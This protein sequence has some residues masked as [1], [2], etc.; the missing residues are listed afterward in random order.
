MAKTQSQGHTQVRLPPKPE[1]LTK[2]LGWL[3]RIG[4]DV[5]ILLA[6]SLYPHD[7]WGEVSSQDNHS[8]AP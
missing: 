5:L 2:R 8:S 1:L 6:A 4:A 3:P 7:W